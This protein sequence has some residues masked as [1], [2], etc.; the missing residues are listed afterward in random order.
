[1]DGCPSLDGSPLNRTMRPSS[2]AL[3]MAPKKASTC[4]SGE[5]CRDWTLSSILP[6]STVGTCRFRKPS[7]CVWKESVGTKVEH[8]GVPVTVY[9]LHCTPKRVTKREI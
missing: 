5:I 8:T 1:M 7:S 3:Q 6:P 4:R 2:F 9:E